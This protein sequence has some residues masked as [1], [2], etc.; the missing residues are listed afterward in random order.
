LSSAAPRSG[1]TAH[2]PAEVRNILVVAN[3][4]Q[5]APALAAT[6]RELVAAE[7]VRVHLLSP[8]QRP[9]GHAM[10]YLRHIDVDSVQ[11]RDGEQALA[12]LRRALDDRG[13]PYSH[14]VEIGPWLDTIARF[15]ADRCCRRIFVGDNRRNFLK[16]LALRHDCARIRTAA[17]AIGFEC[18]VLRRE[19]GRSAADSL[20]RSPA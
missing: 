3:G 12:P 11:H 17:K 1:F 7:G 20:G 16:D 9:S 18:T 5:D 2:F 15:A 8:Q 19:P 10:A 4:L 13:V 6:L 14:H